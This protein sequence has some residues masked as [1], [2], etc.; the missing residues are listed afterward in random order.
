MPI[1]MSINCHEQPI[2]CSINV[3]GS[4]AGIQFSKAA[5]MK[6]KDSS[7]SPRIKPFISKQPN[8]VFSAKNQIQK[9]L[10]LE[11]EETIVNE[12]TQ[13]HMTEGISKPNFSLNKQHMILSRKL[14]N[15]LDASPLKNSYIGK[16][17]HDRY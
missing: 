7:N 12:S 10:Q 14:S 4:G 15:M 8:S 2:N 9:N 6:L 5:L 17:I 3:A 13:V 11:N 1:I 16:I